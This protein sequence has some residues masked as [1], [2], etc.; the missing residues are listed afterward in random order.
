M[1][2]IIK[3]ALPTRFKKILSKTYQS[4]KFYNES[5]QDIKKY[6]KF[7]KN[8][9]FMN[10][11]MAE[12]ELIFYYHK[13]EK[14][15]SLS[16]PKKRFGYEAVLKLMKLLKEYISNYG[17]DDTALVTLKNLKQYVEFNEEHGVDVTTI[18]KA[19]SVLERQLVSRPSEE[20]GTKFLNK[21]SDITPYLVDFEG[22]AYSRHSIRDFTG[23]K[24]EDDIIHRA[25]NIAQKTPSVCNRQSSRVYVYNDE[26]YKRKVFSFQNGNKG[27]G[28]SADKV[29][30]ITTKIDHFVG[31]N[32]RNQNF[33][34]GGMYAMSLIY[35]LHSLG[36]GTCAL[37]L[38]L[39]NKK[40]ETLKR[41]G[42]VPEDERVI[43]MIAV[44]QIPE[45]LKVAASPRREVSRVT[46][47]F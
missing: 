11:S 33:I 42:D 37:N 2:T 16:K 15:L 7:S 17:W 30:L 44:G 45:Q 24:V 3:S 8:K 39:P 10:Q 46:K 22:L 4:S 19:V 43:M 13:I 1:K 41:A 21:Q 6:K 9:K 27:F 38:A 35:S 5:L 23:E 47:W 31:V 14:G 28:D 32:E 26:F 40:E 12:A 29:L 34:D 25:I 36:V 20:G 18:N